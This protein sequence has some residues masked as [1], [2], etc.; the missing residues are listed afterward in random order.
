MVKM[1]PLLYLETK[2]DII[3]RFRMCMLISFTID[4]L[5]GTLLD[6]AA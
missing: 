2:Q 4:F 3:V 5:Y 1:V 6:Q